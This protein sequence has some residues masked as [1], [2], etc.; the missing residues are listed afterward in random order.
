MNIFTG[1]A[2]QDSLS[3]ENHAI[4]HLINR[5]MENHTCI[6]GFHWRYGYNMPEFFEKLCEPYFDKTRSMYF[7]KNFQPYAM[8]LKTKMHGLGRHSLPEIANFS[9]QDLDAFSLLL[10][11]KPFFNGD[12][13]STIDCTMFG[14][15]VQFIYMPLDIPQKKYIQENC[16]NLASFVDRMRCQLWPDWDEMCQ[17]SCMEGKKA[18]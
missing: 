14:H 2:Q 16:S 18:I 3:P 9:F 4:S 11:D 10:G 6:A 17:G 12:V 5:T 7:F 13:P 1:L 8:I 15:L